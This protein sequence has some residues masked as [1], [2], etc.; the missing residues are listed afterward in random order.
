MQKILF[1]MV[2]VLAIALLAFLSFSQRETTNSVLAQTS[3][4]RRTVSTQQLRGPGIPAITPHLSSPSTS[5]FTADD[6][7]HYLETHSLPGQF[8]LAPGTK[9]VIVKIVFLP[10][11][12]VTQLAE[13]STGMPD[14]YL[15]CYVELHG[16]VKISGPNGGTGIL[17]TIHIVFDAQTGNLLMI[18]GQ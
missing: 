13:E 11:K 12:E 4:I 6:V 3:S 17:R 16:T 9:F 15:L 18:G 1:L 2:A 10:S 7:R 5:A 14:S 8:S